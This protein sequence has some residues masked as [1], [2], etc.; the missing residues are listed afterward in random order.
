MRFVPIKTDDQLDLGIV[1]RQYSTGGKVRLF[2]ISERGNVY[3]RKMLIHG[4]RAA[5]LR[6]KRDL[7]SSEHSW[8]DSTP[9]LPRTTRRVY[10]RQLRF[11]V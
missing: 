7:R 5:V 2:G 4:A 1:L 6:G 9:G 10:Q 11:W 3:L 8:I